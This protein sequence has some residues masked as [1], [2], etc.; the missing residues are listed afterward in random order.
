MTMTEGPGMIALLGSGETAPSSGVVYDRLTARAE[1]PLQVSILETPAG[2]QPNSERV[3]AKVA[4]FLGV[5]LQNL[6][7]EI[8]LLP[9]R[10]RDTDHS[11]D[12]PAASEAML[13]SDLIFLGPGSPTYAARQLA[14]TLAW[15]R[16]QARHRRGAAVVTASAATIAVGALAL[17]V[18]EIYKVGAEL[19][20]QP[21]LDLLAP[22]G[23]SIVFVPHW[24]NAEGGA[25]LDTS[26]CYMGQAR[27]ERL[28]GMLPAGQTVVGVDEHTG[29]VLDLAGGRAE[30]MGKGGVTVARDGAS[31]YY[32]RKERFALG[33]LGPFKLIDPREGLPP[34]VWAETASRPRAAPEQPAAPDEVLALVEERQGARARRDWAGADRLRDAIA[35]AGWQVKDTPA[36]PVVE[37]A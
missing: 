9:A 18:Y 6:R 30:V 37:P 22:Y 23:L 1:A 33:E 2:F 15:H 34:E 19:H 16:L 7:P 12:D 10:A 35:A 25:E 4:E 13:Q 31:R 17:P 27:Y 8:A 20:W 24:N 26:R 21:G 29:L 28:L 36:G 14:G 11:P 32:P 5:R 3:A